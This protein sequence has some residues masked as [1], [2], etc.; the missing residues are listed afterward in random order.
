MRP[1]NNNRARS[2]ALT[3]L[4]ALHL[5]LLLLLPCSS[6]RTS[7]SDYD[8]EITVKREAEVCSV[9]DDRP[10][11]LFPLCTNRVLRD[12]NRICHGCE[13]GTLNVALREF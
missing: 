13:R 10:Y 7:S 3:N 12:V 9:D 5:L 8:F 11:K 6:Y 4:V 2:L 1:M